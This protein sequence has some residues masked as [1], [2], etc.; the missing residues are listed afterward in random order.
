LQV[1]A[2]SDEQSRKSLEAYRDVPIKK[3]C[4][5]VAT[6]PQ[7]HFRPDRKPDG[8]LEW[9]VDLEVRRR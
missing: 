2:V 7:S 9:I 4:G 1:L 6:I 5:I 3:L 8:G